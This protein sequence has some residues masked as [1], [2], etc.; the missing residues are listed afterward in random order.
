MILNKI[1]NSLCN[2]HAEDTLKSQT[3]STVY[4]NAIRYRN[5]RRAVSAAL[6]AAMICVLVIGS[7]GGYQF[8]YTPVYAISID[9]NPSIE[10]G[11][12]RFDK[13][14]DVTGYNDDGTTLAESVDVKNMNYTDALQALLGT[15]TVRGYTDNGADVVVAVSGDDEQKTS[16]MVTAV[17]GCHNGNMNLYCYGSDSETVQEAHDHDLSLG[18]Y[19]AY[20]ELKEYDP[21]ISADDIR[22]MS[23]REIRD[24]INQYSGNTSSAP[25]DNTPSRGSGQ[26][27]HHGKH[28]NGSQQYCQ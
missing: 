23:M 24:L 6:T 8:Y 1:H 28:G 20:L 18:K 21:N 27:N 3:K 10:L 4:K 12:N 2:V 19:R 5:K 14:V 9:I 22:N 15:E 11:I 17:Q 26:G 7:I 13:V 25:S 16:E